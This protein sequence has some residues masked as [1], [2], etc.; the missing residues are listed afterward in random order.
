TRCTSRSRSPKSR[1]TLSQPA[2]SDS[3]ANSSRNWITSATAVI[4]STPQS[5]SSKTKK[6]TA[7]TTEIDSVLSSLA[8]R[9][10][11]D[12]HDDNRGQKSHGIGDGGSVLA[13]F[14]RCRFGLASLPP[15]DANPAE[16]Q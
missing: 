15:I 12:H 10:A 6:R 7:S 11:H 4:R 8:A 14:R 13:G 3:G 16:E 2:A 5:G 9:C 1:P